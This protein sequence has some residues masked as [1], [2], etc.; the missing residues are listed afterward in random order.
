MFRAALFALLLALGSFACKPVSEPPL[1]LAP[2]SG[3]QIFMTRCISCHQ[4][5]GSGIPEICPPL[6]NSPR[7]TGHPEDLIRIMLLGMKGP[8]I[9]DGR[10]YNSIMP[11]WKYDLTD[12]QIAEVINDLHM[13]WNPRSPRVTEELVRRIRAE[14]AGQK[15]FPTEKELTLQN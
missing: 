11:A 14:T 12:L 7:L 15:L 10:P 1:E 5:D 13:R 4:P 8:I 9:R 3:R 2:L 6:A